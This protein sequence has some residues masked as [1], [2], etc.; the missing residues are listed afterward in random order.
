MA[1]DH[2]DN[3]HYPNQSYGVIAPLAVNHA[4]IKDLVVRVIPNTS[5]ELERDSVFGEI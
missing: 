4:I 3:R 1:V 2:D 5:S